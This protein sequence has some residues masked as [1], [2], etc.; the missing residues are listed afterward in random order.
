MSAMP[1]CPICCL[2]VPDKENVLD[3][4]RLLKPDLDPDLVSALK[5][6]LLCTLLVGNGNTMELPGA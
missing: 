3:S 5:V 6:S 2:G 4:L 1:A